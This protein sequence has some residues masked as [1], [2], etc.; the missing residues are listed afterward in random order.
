MHRSST[1]VSLRPALGCSVV[2]VL[3]IVLCSTTA[4]NPSPSGES[5]TTQ[6]RAR[7]HSVNTLSCKH[8]HT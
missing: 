5:V 1:S 2:S 6:N 3:L 4:T 7:E 8:Q